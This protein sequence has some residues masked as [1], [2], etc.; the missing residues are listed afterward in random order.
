MMCMKVRPL[1][2]HCKSLLIVPAGRTAH[3]REGLSRMR[4]EKAIETRRTRTRVRTRRSR[5]MQR[6]TW[7]RKPT[8]TQNWMRV[9]R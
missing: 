7:M 5:W 4:M 8:E 9:Q 2:A 3:Q 1:T 6:Q